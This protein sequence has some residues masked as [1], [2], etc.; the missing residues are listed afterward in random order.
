MFTFIRCANV[1]YHPFSK[2]QP[3]LTKHCID[4]GPTLAK[5]TGLVWCYYIYKGDE[6]TWVRQCH[7]KYGE[8]VRLGPD[9]LS[10][11]N[12]QAWKDISGFRTGGRLEN[13]KDYRTSLQEGPNSKPSVINQTD[14]QGHGRIRKIFTNAFSDKALK[15]Q[16]PMVYTH[17]NKLIQNLYHAVSENPDVKF[18]M[19]KT[20]NCATFDIMGDL[21]FGEPLGMLDTGE[22]TPWVKAVFGGL[23]MGTYFRIGK[24]FP[25][26]EFFMSV[27]T[28][29]SL[30]DDLAL[31][32]N[33][34]IERVNRR[35]EKGDDPSK[36][37]IWKLVMDKGKDLLSL[38]E[39]HSNASL[40]MLA[41]TETTASVLSGAT[42]YLLKNPSKMQKLVEEIRKLSLEQ[43]TFEELAR[44]PYMSACLEETLRCYPPVP[45]ASPRVIA[46]GGNAV[47]GDW[48]PEGVCNEQ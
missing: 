12:S 40:F 21:A 23:K 3:L 28:P 6:T 37:D 41:G 10:Y 14:P 2:K 35:I 15:L 7:E 30:R 34:A 5:A 1:S 46:P 20:Y 32:F 44:L 24:E 25:L 38:Q 42:F 18:E 31:H 39:M 4:P 9:R 11:I 19:V 33:H 29:Q 17:I 16:E 47:M 26:L 27:F 22:Y 36:A 48:L 13:S 45:I 8:V 43:L